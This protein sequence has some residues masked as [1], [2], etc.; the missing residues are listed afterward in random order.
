MQKSLLLGGLLGG[1]VLFVWNS[2]SWNVLPWHMMTFEKFKD[3]ATIAQA[4]TVNALRPGVYLLPNAHKHDPGVTE[5]QKKAE[6]VEGMKRMIQGPLMFASV[7][8]QG[9]EGIGPALLIQLVTGIVGTLLA[10]W[11]LLQT[12]PMGYWDR[13]GFLVVISL[14]VAVIAQLPYWNWWNFST[15]YTAVTIADLLI[16]WFL[17]SLVIAKMLPASSGS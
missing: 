5:E 3:E 7:S 4:L 10:T 11:L 13:V 12:R 17:A 2:I 14:V 6:E 15:S 9:F 16:G 1:L 8:L